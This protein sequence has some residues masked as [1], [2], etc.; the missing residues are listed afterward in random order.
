M[1]GSGP[2]AG[3]PEGLG[4]W[5]V[6]VGS[7]LAGGR[8]AMDILIGIIALVV[9]LGICFA[10]FRVFLIMLPIWGFV[11]GF[12]LGA[13]GMLVLFGQGFLS[14]VASWVVG[15]IVGLVFAVLSYLY[16]YV[17][18]AI[19]GA[20]VGASI[21]TG[22]FLA[23]GLDAAWLLWLVAIVL[24]VIFALGVFYLNVPKYLVIVFTAIN[25]ALIAIAGALMILDRIDAAELGTGAATAIVNESWFW[26]IVWAVLA[27]IGMGAQLQ[28]TAEIESDLRH[29]REQPEAGMATA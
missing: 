23:I 12:W 2:S 20:T 7:M 29:W 10:G 1:A 16:W 27:A 18:V 19:L 3:P 15:V 11:A 5:A 17:S 24:G 6:E 22:I 28:T 9:G 8:S 13:A 14:T 21:G 26:L 4:R 25:G